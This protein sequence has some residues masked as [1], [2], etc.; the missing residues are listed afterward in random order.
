[1]GPSEGIKRLENT[2]LSVW[3][4]EI[5]C[6]GKSSSRYETSVCGPG[7]VI[8]KGIQVSFAFRSVHTTGVHGE[9]FYHEV[10]RSTF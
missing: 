4:L 5:I 3:K 9:S 10:L 8:Y 7:A 6:R 2:Q 1:M